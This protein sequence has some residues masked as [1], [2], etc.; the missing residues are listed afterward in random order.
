MK[1]GNILD[2]KGEGVVTIDIGQTIKAAADAMAHHQIAALVITE[3]AAPVGLV[4]ERD[5]VEALAAHGEHGGHRPLRQLTR[6]DLI[7]VAP[8]E[9]IKR[10]MAMM[11]HGRMRHLPVIENGALAGIVSLGDIVKYRLEELEMESNVLR[12]ITIA[13]R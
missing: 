7:S 5:V 13:L 2:H 11:T 9:T 3:G 12:D 4:S 8:N 6:G 10:A 1:I